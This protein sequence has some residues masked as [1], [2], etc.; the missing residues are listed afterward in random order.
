MRERCARALVRLGLTLSLAVASGIAAQP[1][2]VV[3]TDWPGEDGSTLQDNVQPKE[4]DQKIL[5]IPVVT[6]EEPWDPNNNTLAPGIKTDFENAAAKMNEFWLENSFGQI[7]FQ[8]TVL[9]RVYQMPMGRSFYFNPPYIQPKVFG[10]SIDGPVTVPAGKLKLLLHISQQDETPL[11]ISFAAAESPFTFAALQTKICGNLGVGDKLKCEVAPT[12][13]MKA[14]LRLE[15]S[16]EY[17]TAGTFVHVEAGSDEDVLDALGLTTPAIDLAT[18]QF[19]TQGTEFPVTTLGGTSLTV[20]VTGTGGTENFVWPLN[21][22]TFNDAAAFV[23][24][25]GNGAANASITAAPDGELHFTLNPTTVS[26][27]F[28]EITFNAP[29]ATLDALGLTKRFETDG[30]IEKEGSNTVRGDW[31]GMVGQGIASYLIYELTRPWGGPGNDPIPNLDIVPANEKALRDTVANQIDPYRVIILMFLD[32]PADQRAG[33]A[34]CW[35]PIGIENAGWTF[36]DFTYGGVQIDYD[37]SDAQLIAHE[38]GHNIGFYDLYDNSEDYLAG[39]EFA[40]NWDTMAWQTEFPHTGFWHKEAVAKWL[41]GKNAAMH[42]FAEPPNFGSETQKYVITPVEISPAEYDAQLAGVPAGRKL[43]KGV[44]LPLNTNPAAEHYLVLENRQKGTAFSQDLPHNAAGTKGGLYIE[45]AISP[46]NWMSHL[47]LASTR[48]VVHPLTD[49]PLNADGDVVPIVDASPNA[50]LNLHGTFPAYDGINVDVVGELPGPGAFAASK[51]L[52]VD[53][54]RQ[55]KNF[56]DLEIKPWGAPPYE[57]TDI[58]IE[59]N[60]GSLSNAPLPGNGQA[61]R[62]AANWD[63]GLNG[64]LNLVRVKVTNHG[65]IIATGVR[66]QA[67]VN[68][69]GGMGDTGK[70]LELDKSDPQDIPPG[71]SRIFNIGWSPKVAAH[72]CLQAEVKEWTAQ[73]GDRDPWNQRTQENVNDFYPTSSSPWTIMPVEFDVASNRDHPV[74]VMFQAQNLPPGYIL[75][76]DQDFFVLPP[77]SKVRITGTLDLDESVI[78]PYDGE[79]RPRPRKPGVFHIAGYILGGDYQL[80]MGGV[81]YRVFPSPLVNPTTTVTTDA[82]GNVVVTGTS[83]PAQPGD[84]VEILICYISGKCEWV[85]VT[86]DANGGINATIDPKEDGPVRVTVY[87]PPNYSPKGASEVTVDPGH[88]TTPGSGGGAAGLN[89]V[90]FFIGGFFPANKLGMESGFNTGFRAGRHFHPQ[91][92]A[93]GEA[94]IVFTSVAGTDGLLGHLTANVLWH[95]FNGKTRP[96]VL[97]GIGGAKFQSSGVSDST[98]AAVFGLGANFHWHPKVGFRFDIRNFRMRDLF[99]AGRT[100]NL[101]GT[102]GVVFRY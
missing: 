57:S 93:E 39:Y 47:F 31:L 49:Q 80:P 50:D 42:V 98:L 66:V 97:L 29:F 68:Q 32:E 87:T 88:P 15:V 34:C 96:F 86:T 89:E 70:W 90:G 55:Q 61:A 83:H 28:T 46:P 75:N 78:P 52:L 85:T 45:D 12:G 22:Q 59:H 6:N 44:R 18:T 76:L 4:F 73:F 33:A 5:V 30:V 21:A 13:A 65:T 14:Q 35:I 20:T 72:T 7:S 94:G 56:L 92:S 26:A 43:T 3:F 77:K 2:V 100:N 19:D 84:T 10:W 23:A 40:F 54:T 1:K 17:V 9:D 36:T 91:F 82:N 60:D 24:A 38:A 58:W 37:S 51:S 41:S 25:H 79:P 64:H 95:P 62:W 71:E 11:E 53:V 99:A 8:T 48:N 102:W 81:T 67:R 74:N 69:P 63:V 27:P 101:Q 16:P